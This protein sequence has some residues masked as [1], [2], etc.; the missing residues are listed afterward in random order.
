LAKKQ[1]KPAKR[2]RHPRRP[3]RSISYTNKDGQPN[4]ARKSGSKER[5]TLLHNI[6]RDCKPVDFQMDPGSRAA[7]V[8]P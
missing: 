2:L 5:Q 1:S 4:L 6:Q 8:Q 7:C 3:P